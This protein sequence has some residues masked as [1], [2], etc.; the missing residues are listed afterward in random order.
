M[1]HRLDGIGHINEDLHDVMAEKCFLEVELYEN[2]L[3]DVAIS[4]ANGEMIYFYS[5]YT[6]NTCEIS[7]QK[8][9]LDDLLGCMIMITVAS[10]GN[11]NPYESFLVFVAEDHAIYCS[12]TPK[13]WREEGAG[14]YYPNMLDVNEDSIYDHFASPRYLFYIPD[15]PYGVNRQ[16]YLDQARRP[17]IDS[18]GMI[19]CRDNTLEVLCNPEAQQHREAWIDTMSEWLAESVELCQTYPSLH[20]VR[21]TVWALREALSNNNVQRFT[22]LYSEVIPYP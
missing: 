5:D 14:P 4:N 2:N 18:R 17:Y 22:E 21:G 8:F 3:Y 16:L 10:G 7:Y 20:E 12:E 13:D 9:I 1:T 6:Y 15:A 11:Y 19:S